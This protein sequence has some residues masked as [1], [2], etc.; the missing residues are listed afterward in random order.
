MSTEKMDRYREL[1]SKYIEHSVNLH[2]YHRVF[3]KHVGYDTGLAIRKNIRSMIEIEKEL[4]NLCREAYFENKQ[5]VKI[6]KQAEKA[7]LLAE[8]KAN[9]RPPGRP[10]KERPN[11]NN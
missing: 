3:I 11:D 4:K 5:N 7:R 10:K 6:A 9:A 1:Y 2:N 8:A